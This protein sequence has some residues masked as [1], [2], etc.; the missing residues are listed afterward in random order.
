MRAS[1]R[2]QASAWGRRSRRTTAGQAG[3]EQRP[4]V[5][6]KG[7]TIVTWTVEDE[8]GNKT[9]ATQKVTV[10]DTEKPIFACQRTGRS[11]LI[12]ARPRRRCPVSSR[13]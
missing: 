12:L 1:A 9:T 3:D 13:G 6:R 5:F 11:H 10:N 4:A 7:D 2:P 8:A